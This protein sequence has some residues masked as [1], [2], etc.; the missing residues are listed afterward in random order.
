MSTFSARDEMYLC[1]QDAGGH[2]PQVVTAPVVQVL[3]PRDVPLGGPRAMTVRRTIPHRERSFIGAWCFVDH[4][5]PDD[6]A[7]TGGMNVPPHPHT[8]L[9]TVTWLF[10]GQVEHRDSGGVHATIRPGEVNLMTGGSG[11]AHSEVSTTA[12]TVLHGVQL[13]VVLPFKYRNLPRRFQHYAPPVVGVSPGVQARVFMGALA[14]GDAPPC[15]EGVPPSPIETA[16]PLLGVEIT[17]AAGFTWNIPVDPTFEHGVLIDAGDVVLA[18]TPLTRGDL[19]IV[20]CGPSTISVTAHSDARF[21]LL[22]GEPFTEEVVMWWNF[23]APDHAGIVA[24]REAWQARSERFGDVLG[25]T[26]DKERLDAPELPKVRLRP[27]NRLGKR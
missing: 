25:Y 22:G 10:D 27:R 5:G 17:M 2:Q 1:P 4:Y 23:I 18:D 21:L 13:W 24:A 6:T 3:T 9:Q 20:D 14:T 11:I 26:G 15:S 7:A 8:G 16:T 12:T 19:G